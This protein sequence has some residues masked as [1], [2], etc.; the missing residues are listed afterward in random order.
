MSYKVK[1]NRKIIGDYLNINGAMNLAERKNGSVYK[2][3]RLVYSF[4]K[5]KKRK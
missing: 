5:H 2:K 3:N 4:P 1:K